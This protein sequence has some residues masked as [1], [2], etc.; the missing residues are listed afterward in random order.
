[1]LK[2]NLRGQVPSRRK[3]SSLHSPPWPIPRTHALLVPCKI[4]MIMNRSRHSCGQ[5]TSIA[6]FIATSCSTTSQRLLQPCP[7]LIICSFPALLLKLIAPSI[8]RLGS[9][10][11]HITVRVNRAQQTLNRVRFP[12]SLDLIRRHDGEAC[13]AVRENCDSGQALY[14]NRGQHPRGRF[15]AGSLAQERFRPSIPQI[16][17]TWHAYGKIPMY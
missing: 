11:G 4:A 13:I 9:S 3:P 6:R 15:V 16:D 12:S 10:E 8:S 5:R 2:H 17:E 7:P 1:M 14:P